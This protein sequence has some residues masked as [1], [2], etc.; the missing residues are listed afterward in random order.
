MEPPPLKLLLAVH[1]LSALTL[2]SLESATLA[3]WSA[4]RR[5]ETADQL[6][7]TLQT[8]RRLRPGLRL[9]PAL[10]IGSGL[11]MAST[12]HLMQT[13]WIVLS[14]IGVALIAGLTVLM[15]IPATQN[16][17]AHVRQGA[18]GLQQAKEQLMA[19]RLVLGSTLKFALLTWV[20]LL[21]LAQP[22]WP[23]GVGIGIVSVV[24]GLIRGGW[25]KRT[26][27]AALS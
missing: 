21:M 9:V 19:R 25:P 10:L 23:E 18:A 24:G 14:L 7:G 11:W 4:A 8:M 12:G 15:E 22:G 6:A 3:L 26:R 20:F 2:F 16:L 5:S 1:V 13:A 27:T 17:E